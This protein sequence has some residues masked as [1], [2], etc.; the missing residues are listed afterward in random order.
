MA[1]RA[2]AAAIQ[3]RPK[4]RAKQCLAGHYSLHSDH[5]QHFVGFH[6]TPAEALTHSLQ[7]K[8][9]PWPGTPSAAVADRTLLFSTWKLEVFDGSATKHFIV[10]D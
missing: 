1:T 7:S 4:E 8:A 9:S 5:S 3:R 2:S 10:L 6:C